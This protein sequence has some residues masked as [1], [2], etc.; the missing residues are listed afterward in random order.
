MTMAVGEC[1]W[2]L[3]CNKQKE[4]N[5]IKIWLM[6]TTDRCTRVEMENHDEYSN[7]IDPYF[8]GINKEWLP[9]KLVTRRKGNKSDCAE[10][11]WG[12][13]VFMR[14]A[15]EVLA[16]IIGQ[17]VEFL[18]V[19]HEEHELF[20]VKVNRVQDIVDMSNPVERRINYGFFSDFVHIHPEKVEEDAHIFRVPQRTSYVYVSDF[21]KQ[22]VE[23]NKLKGFQFIEIWDTNHTEDVRKER[24]KRFDI[25]YEGLSLRE[26]VSFHEAWSMV[27]KEGKMV[28][29][30]N[31]IIKKSEGAI[32]I[33]EIFANET[34]RWVDPTYI[35]PLYMDLQWIVYGENESE[36]IVQEYF[37]E[38]SFE[39]N[40]PKGNPVIIPDKILEAIIRKELQLYKDDLTETSL[41]KLIKVSPMYGKEPPASLRGLEFAKNLMMLSIDNQS[42][43]DLKELRHL[44][45]SLQ[46]LAMRNC[47]LSDITMMQDL[48]L[49]KI[50]SLYLGDNNIDDLSPLIKFSSTIDH[51]NLESNR[52]NSILPLNELQ[53]LK[54]IL[55]RNNPVT[56][57][58]ELKLPK[59]RYLYIDGIQTEDWSFLLTNFPALEYV[60]ISDEGMTTASANSLREVIKGKQFTVSWSKS[61]TGDFKLYNKK[62]KK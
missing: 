61:A 29:N 21:F 42:N 44:P 32:L 9:V 5:E 27:S 18:P 33:G 50:S 41:Q 58:S 36:R 30:N 15:K 17:D 28:R 54:Y 37:S 49:P 22:A 2:L 35:A 59:L 7:S 52:I 12:Y 26:K 23:T 20:L 38:L 14:T 60:S 8:K 16:P 19:I 34:V 46:S 31:K 10:F 4:L 39:V 40:G 62:I 55:V 51:I 53:L 43:F 45:D 57:I 6:V 24:L 25:Y 48:T 11:T 13:P 3:N 56:D 1:A 47:G